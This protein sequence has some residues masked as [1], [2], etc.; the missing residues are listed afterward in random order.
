MIMWMRILD[1]IIM[2][3]ADVIGFSCYIWNTDLIL[4][5]SQNIKKGNA[6]D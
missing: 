1:D 5:L 2:E 4:E 6:R 3:K